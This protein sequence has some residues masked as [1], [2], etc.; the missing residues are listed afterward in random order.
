MLIPRFTS[1][2][3]KDRKRAGRR[4]K[5]LNRLDV[6]M[7]RLAQREVLESRYRDHKLTGEWHD[8]RECHIEPDWLLI[9]RTVASEITFVRTGTHAD[10]FDE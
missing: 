8:F 9:Y 4:G 7:R 3:K 5:D 1:A 6:I 10:L 2:F